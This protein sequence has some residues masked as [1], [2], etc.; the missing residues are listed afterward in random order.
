MH[1]GEKMA[2]V[3][4]HN[5][6]WNFVYHLIAAHAVPLA[7]TCRTEVKVSYTQHHRP[8]LLVEPHVHVI[9]C[10]IQYLDRK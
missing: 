8:M 4:N 1:V 3:N 10:T 7:F 2:T 6:V 5:G 9:E